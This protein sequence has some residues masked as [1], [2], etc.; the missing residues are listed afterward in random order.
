[1]TSTQT[2]L[3]IDTTPAFILGGNARFTIRSK[4]TGTRFS[5]RVRKSED[6]SIFFV[7]VL[8]GSD[9]DSDFSYIG[10][11]TPRGPYRHGKKSKITSTAPSAAAFAWFWGSLYAG[12]PSLSDQ[13][14]V[15]H[16]GRCGR[17]ARAL[18][19]PESIESG[20]GPEC[21]NHVS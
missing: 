4:K 3:R 17:C 18:T 15:F 1:M 20:F 7:S 12:R 10:T 14:E 5:Y 8:T 6:G 13:V 11:L 16:E 2:A 19:V 21:I 9:N